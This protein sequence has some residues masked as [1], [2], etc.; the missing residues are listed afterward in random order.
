MLILTTKF[1]FSFSPPIYAA[2]KLNKP[3]VFLYIYS[4]IKR[5]GA[6]KVSG[7]K[8]VGSKANAFSSL[9][10]EDLDEEL[11]KSK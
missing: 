3:K 4:M 2:L 8:T 5:K 6:G 1:D 7:K 9:K 10:V 11:L